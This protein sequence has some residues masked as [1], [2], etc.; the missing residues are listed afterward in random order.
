MPAGRSLAFV[1]DAS[2]T[3]LVLAANEDDATALAEQLL[4]VSTST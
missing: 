4:R 3:R 1:R 2:R